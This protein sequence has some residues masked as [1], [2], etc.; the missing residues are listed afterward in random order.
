MED[1]FVVE[2]VVAELLVLLEV[3]QRDCVN[4]RSIE[5]VEGAAGRLRGRPVERR[6]D[7]MRER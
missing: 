6:M 5:V 1:C 2:I 3:C 4:S 7:W